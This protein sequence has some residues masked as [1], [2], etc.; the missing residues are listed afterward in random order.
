M[1]LERLFRPKPAALA[2]RRLYDAAANQARTPAFYANLGAPDTMEGRFELYSLHVILLLDR[3]KGETDL[4]EPRQSLFDSYVHGLDDALREIGVADTSVA[5]KMKKLAG[6]FYGRLRGY[7]AAFGAL[8]DQAELA[9]LI[10]RTLF[11]EADDSRAAADAASA[12]AARTALAGQGARA[13]V[14]GAA[15]AWP[16]IAP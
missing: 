6:A 14:D 16:P 12:A 15:P 11:G 13:L 4:V 2:G 5:K 1:F 10:G 3:L 9:A 8:P 7:D